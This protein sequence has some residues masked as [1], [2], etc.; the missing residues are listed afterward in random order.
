MSH[1]EGGVSG[2]HF[3]LLNTSLP[4]LLCT[5]HPEMEF[6]QLCLQLTLQQTHALGGMSRD[7]RGST[8]SP[9]SPALPYPLPLPHGHPSLTSVYSRC[10]RVASARLSLASRLPGDPV[11]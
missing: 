8:T 9:F 3:P 10:P 5:F 1:V 6:A 7:R 2:T 4:P 11:L